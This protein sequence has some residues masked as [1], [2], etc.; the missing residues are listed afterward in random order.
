M[1][2]EDILTRLGASRV[3]TASSLRQA[4]AELAQT[5]FEVAVLDVNLGHET[6]LP[7]ADELQARGVPY[8]FATGYG[9]QLRLSEEQ[10]QVPVIQKPYTASSMAAAVERLLER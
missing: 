8:L 6:S 1:D 5:A 4:R 7:F 9:D 3:V 10:A 2:A